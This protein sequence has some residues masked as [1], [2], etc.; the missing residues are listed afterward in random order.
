LILAAAPAGAQAEHETQHNVIEFTD[1]F[2]S[3]F[4]ETC[5]P[6]LGNLTVQGEE[7]VSFTDTGATLQV[8]VN[9][10]GSFTLDPHDPGLL[11]SSGH[12]I[13]QHRENVNYGQLSDWR[14][15]DTTHAVAKFEDGSSVPVHMRTTLL[16]SADGSVESRSTASSAGARR[17]RR[18]S[19]SR[20]PAGS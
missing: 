15:T 7:V 14:V 12:F 1:P 11:S 20:R 19:W 10:H 18:P 5:E 2:F 17:P 4:T 8:H 3:G 6:A 16:F 13:L 9:A